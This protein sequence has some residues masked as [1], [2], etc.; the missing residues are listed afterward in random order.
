MDHFIRVTGRFCKQSLDNQKHLDTIANIRRDVRSLFG[1]SVQYVGSEVDSGQLS[2]LFVT[3]TELD[4]RTVRREVTS[5]VRS[6]K[7]LKHGCARL[8]TRDAVMRDINSRLLQD[9]QAA[10]DV[11]ESYFC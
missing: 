5:L 7:D 8:R 1:P 9:Y 10:R 2:M 6:H 4:K 3:D 11:H